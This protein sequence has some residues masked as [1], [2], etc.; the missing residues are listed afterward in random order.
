[1]YGP[2]EGKRHDAGMMAQSNLLQ[3]LALH[4][5]SATGA[6]LCIYGDPA[7]PLRLHL[8]GPFKS[9]QLSVNEKA[10]NMLMSKARVSIEWIFGDI[11]NYFAFLDFKKK[12]NVKLSAVGKMYITCALMH[13]ARTCLYGNV[14]SKFFGKDP[15]T[16]S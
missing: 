11:I 13:N 4:S 16:L 15:P 9:R 3:S 2:I 5:H 7:Y 14:T 12:L 10:Y 1:M 8:Q 6:I